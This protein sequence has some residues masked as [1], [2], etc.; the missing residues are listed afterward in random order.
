[1]AE[2]EAADRHSDLVRWFEDA[3]KTSAPARERSERDRDYYD[4]IQW[5][6][7]EVE[8]LR[9]RG[10]PTL[11]INYLKDKVELLRGLER[12]QRSDPKAFPRTPTEDERADVATQALRYVAD[13]NTFDETRSGVY[14]NL[15]IE[16]YGGAEVVIEPGADGQAEIVIRHIPWDRLF[17]DPHSR[18]P[19]FGDARY[20]GIVL[21]MDR[22]EALE[23]FPDA[24]EVVEAT[25]SMSGGSGGTYDDRPL[26][27]WTDNRRTRVRIVQMHYRDRGEWWTATF[28]K[29]GHVSPPVRSPYLGPDGKTACPLILRHAYIDRQNNRYGFLRDLI[30]PQDEVNKRRSK[31]L[32]WANSRQSII[33]QGAVDDPD[34]ARREMARPDGQIVVNPGMRFDI[35]PSAEFTAA[36]MALLQHA[37]SEIQN[38]GPNASMAGQDPR[39]LSGRAIQAQQ[40]GGAV[41]A[42][43][44]LDGLRMWSRDVFA[45]VWMRARQ[46]WTGE[47]WIRITDDERNVR[48]VG[49]NRQ[50][51]LADELGAMP[52]EQRAMAMQQLQLVPGDPRL[53]QV[54]RTE[55]EIGDLQADI[56]IEEGPDTATLQSEQFQ[57]LAEMAQS[58]MPIPPDV[59]IA[60][61]SLR[62]KD[63]LLKRMEA[64]QQ[65]QAQAGQQQQ[66]IGEAQAVAGIR[67]TNA[68]A[69]VKEAQAQGSAAD[70]AQKG[71]GVQA[72]LSGA[73][74][75]PGEAVTPDA[76]QQGFG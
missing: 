68:E 71:L 61:S 15:L 8:T 55:N 27:A 28:T 20:L 51:T 22:E 4:G 26:N 75:L 42:E 2:P 10:Q 43:P 45:A 66:Q 62:N 11:T 29:G 1:M 17:T 47:K 32:H 50:V 5:T 31:A 36:Q 52:E 6:A 25:L 7:E 59:L 44:L 72:M 19:D 13:T 34:K 14:E 37:T 38:R 54:V 49:L 12:R 65:Q 46:F 40:Q 16:G 18:Q 9:K 56:R 70:A 3:E 23:H 58:G 64:A 73:A 76:M 24:G 33:E 63:D 21:W 74:P 53:K 30:S 69:A 41:A 35:L 67:K 60:A 39:A 57:Q 48:W